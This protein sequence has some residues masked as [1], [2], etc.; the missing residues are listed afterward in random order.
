MINVTKFALRTFLHRAICVAN[1]INPNISL[2]NE[3]T[4]IGKT[5]IHFE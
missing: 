3:N 2:K 4:E 1:A 5:H